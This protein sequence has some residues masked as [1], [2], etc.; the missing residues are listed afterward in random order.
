MAKTLRWNNALRRGARQNFTSKILCIDR[1]TVGRHF[2]LDLAGVTDSSVLSRSPS[3][4][5][6][7]PWTQ[8]GRSPRFIINYEEIRIGDEPYCRAG[9][10]CNP[11]S[12]I[13]VD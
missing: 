6:Y 9:M 5:P 2:S 3:S 4:W 13:T 11:A 12:I 7:P 10:G 8:A 1:N